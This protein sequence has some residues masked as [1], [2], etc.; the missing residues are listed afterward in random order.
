MDYYS[1]FTV[2]R[3]FHLGWQPGQQPASPDQG[4]GHWHYGALLSHQ[5]LPGQYEH[6]HIARRH[7]A[8]AQEENH[9]VVP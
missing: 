5:A 7:R 8:S 9:G 4:Q 1:I 2:L 6:L 3:T